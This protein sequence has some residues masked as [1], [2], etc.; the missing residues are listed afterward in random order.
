LQQAQRRAH[1]FADVVVA[2]AFDALAG[3]ALELGRQMHIGGHEP[4][5]VKV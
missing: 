5:Y 3:K 1:D 2:A 4:A